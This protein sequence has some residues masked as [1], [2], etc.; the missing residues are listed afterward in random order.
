M[1][2]QSSNGVTPRLLLRGT[3]F[4]IKVWEALLRIP[5]GEVVSYGDLAR[6][7]GVPNAARAVGNALA[8]NVIAA[9]IP[10]HRVI[11]E[12]GEIGHYRWGSERKMAMLMRETSLAGNR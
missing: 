9:L 2:S 6:R 8:A 3:N 12:S 10:C 7:A 11:R 4:Q 1:F 5:P